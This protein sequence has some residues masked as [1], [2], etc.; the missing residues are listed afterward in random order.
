[1]RS[2]VLQGHSLETET[3]VAVGARLEWLPHRLRRRLSH[4][5]DMADTV[6]SLLSNAVSGPAIACL[7]RPWPAETAYRL[8]YEYGEPDTPEPTR[9]AI[10]ACRGWAAAQHD[11]AVLLEEGSVIAHN[12]SLAVGWYGKA[13]MAGDSFAQNNLGVCLSQGIGIPFD[14][15]A[16]VSWYRKSA[17]QEC[18]EGMQN[19]AF[20]LLCGQCVKRREA[21][22]FRLAMQS[23]LKNSSGR[24]AFLVGQCIRHGWGARKDV[25]LAK[26]W[27][28]FASNRGFTWQTSG[29]KGCKVGRLP[30][31]QKRKGN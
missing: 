4:A 22:A 18:A 16:A 24:S 15:K 9:L 13:A 23:F 12:L 5:M 25:P 27:L 2:S 8:A 20:C 21:L 14:G 30:E 3:L 6:Q 29:W 11:L 31:M 19:Y 1:M 10:A 17:L 28:A 26:S 7:R